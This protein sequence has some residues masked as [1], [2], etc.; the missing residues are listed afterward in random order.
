MPKPRGKTY[1]FA[2][3]F[4]RDHERIVTDLAEAG[5]FGTPVKSRVFEE[6]IRLGLTVFQPNTIVNGV[7]TYDW[8]GRKH[9]VMRYSL[10]ID[11]IEALDKLEASGMSCTFFMNRLFEEGIDIAVTQNPDA[12][13]IVASRKVRQV[14]PAPPDD[15]P[16]PHSIVIRRILSQPPVCA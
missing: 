2:F 16:T 1:Y 7:V 15:G 11:V 10:H 9:S 13:R 14:E 6:I 3:A 5:V 12:A 8:R 4:L